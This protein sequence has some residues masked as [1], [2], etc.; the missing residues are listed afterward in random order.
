MEDEINDQI[1]EAMFKLTRD[2]KGS[3][4]GSF[5]H[6]HLTILQCQALECIKKHVGT[7]MGDIASHF[8]TTMPTATA[9][10]DKLIT[11]KLVKRENDLKDRRIIRISLTKQ[12]EKLLVEVRKQSANK[13]KKL[14][15]YLPKQDKL[16]LLRILEILAQQ[17]ENL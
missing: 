13:M 17:S 9:L 7:H 16:E 11:A 8:A 2:L 6:S 3:I 4:S 5:E 1:L 10:V 15:S 14:L 12:G